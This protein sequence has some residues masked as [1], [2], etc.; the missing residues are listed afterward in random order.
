MGRN[1]ER[2]P[3]PK[4]R[5]AAHRRTVGQHIEAG[6]GDAKVTT[7]SHSDDFDIA[8]GIF[9][10]LKDLPVERQ[11]RVLRWI[12]EGLGVPPIG[13]PQGS[14]QNLREQTTPS[15]SAGTGGGGTAATDIKSFIAVKSPKSDTQF[16]AAVAYYYRFEAPP[17]QKRDAINGDALQEA[18][19]LAGRKRLAS[20]RVT[21]NNAKKAG[22]LDGAS[23]GEFAINSVGE[24]LVA[25]T[26]PGGGDAPPRA[27][28]PKA[29]RKPKGPARK[30][31]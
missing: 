11:Q 27:R 6:R 16:A 22:Y 12:A 26:L 10:Q 29:R 7:H 23:R 4:G 30:T 24:N 2:W 1:A 21:L 25:M 28:A 15:A 20:P 5:R 13:L 3:A 17:A 9:D 19:R 14:S 8:K 31:R 18:A